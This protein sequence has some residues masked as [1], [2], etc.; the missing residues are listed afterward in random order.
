MAEQENK[1]LHILQHKSSRLQ[2]EDLNQPHIPNLIKYLVPIKS[3]QDIPVFLAQ[4]EAIPNVP[5]YMMGNMGKA[6]NGIPSISFEDRPNFLVGSNAHHQHGLSIHQHDYPKPPV[7]GRNR[8]TERSDVST[9]SSISHADAMTVTKT[10][11]VF[12]SYDP[13]EIT[14]KVREFPGLTAKISNDYVSKSIDVGDNF[15]S[16]K[17]I[18]ESNAEDFSSSDKMLRESKDFV[19]TTEADKEDDLEATST[20]TS[21]VTANSAPSIVYSPITHDGKLISMEECM[22]LFGR[23]VCVYRAT[24]LRTSTDQTRENNLNRY[25]TIAVPKYVVRTS[26]KKNTD[27]VDYSEE[28]LA[29]LLK[30]GKNS[31]ENS[32]STNTELNMVGK[33]SSPKLSRY[34]NPIVQTYD[35][36]DSDESS[37]TASISKNWRT[38]MIGKVKTGIN[39]FLGKS[40]NAEDELSLSPN[41]KEMKESVLNEESL[42]STTSR[43]YNDEKISNLEINQENWATS[44]STWKNIPQEEATVASHIDSGT[45]HDFKDESTNYLEESVTNVY[46]EEEIPQERF[47]EE[48]TAKHD[49]ASGYNLKA[50]DFKKSGF[51]TY[52]NEEYLQSATTRYIHEDHEKSNGSSNEEDSFDTTMGSPVGRL[53]F[54]DNTLLLNSI[55]KVINGFTLDTRVGRTKDL[56]ENVLQLHSRSL[57]PE[58]LE[59]PHLKN[60]LLV[61]RIENMIVEKVKDVLSN[62]TAIPRRDFTND[63]SHGI[64]TDTLR[65]MLEAFPD[66]HRKLP[67]MTIE[68]RQFKNGEW[69]SSSVNLASIVGNRLSKANQINLRECI[70]DLLNSSAIASQADQHIVRNIMIQGIKNSLIS[71]E[72]SGEVADPIISDALNDALR[73]LREPDF[74]QM[75]NDASIVAASESPDLSE[76]Y[77][78]SKDTYIE[79]EIPNEAIGTIK[80]DSRDQTLDGIKKIAMQNEKSE[81]VEP[82]APTTINQKTILQDNNLN[83]SKDSAKANRDRLN[84]EESNRNMFSEAI[85]VSSTEDPHEDSLMEKT[86]PDYA[87]DDI[88][89]PNMALTKNI[90]DETGYTSGITT[91]NLIS[92]A[93]AKHENLEIAVTSSA[94]EIDPTIILARL[95][96]NL[97]PIKYYSPETLK[98]LQDHRIEDENEIVTFANFARESSPDH[99]QISDSTTEEDAARSENAEEQT[100]DALNWKASTVWVDDS[101]LSGN[102]P[103]YGNYESRTLTNEDASKLRQQQQRNFTAEDDLVKIHEVTTE[104]QR[105]YAKT[106]F[107]KSKAHYVEDVS[108]IK[109]LSSNPD[110]ENDNHDLLGNTNDINHVSTEANGAIV[111][112]SKSFLNDDYFLRLFPSD[113][114]SE[115]QRSQL[116]YINDDVKLPL[117]IIKLTDGSYALSISKDICE[118]IIRRRCPCCVPLQGRIV[119]S[120]GKNGQKNAN[121]D[122]KDYRSTD[123]LY[124]PISSITTK[125]TLRMRK[126]EKEKEETNAHK[127][128]KRN[129][130]KNQTISM[131]VVDFARKYNLLLNFDK[132]D[133]LLNGMAS[134]GR[135]VE[136][137]RS[138]RLGES[139]LSKLSEIE[140]NMQSI[141]N[142]E[143][144]EGD[145][146]D[147]DERMMK[148]EEETVYPNILRNV[149]VLNRKE[150]RE[151][152]ESGLTNDEQNAS[153]IKIFT[154]R[155]ARPYR[156]EQ[157]RGT[158]II[159]SILY[160]IKSLFEK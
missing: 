72:K 80:E 127:L 120:S 62:V 94:G 29:S 135:N 142:T 138:G 125:S 42:H 156:Y 11:S 19:E 79:E 91:D 23:D 73:I 86:S 146:S 93:N 108:D 66:F 50:M 118:I 114:I 8:E 155:D 89:S 55:R 77:D 61:P 60:I 111:S 153:R 69:K 38:Q 132:E 131:P 56:D 15:Y 140:G 10:G 147:V 90:G 45:K 39:K 6:I 119:Q 102:N 154:E 116:Y 100:E 158:R 57:L 97:P 121:A 103:R 106:T 54:C 65:S 126:Q 51:D 137:G 159:K 49:F 109:L 128:W 17:M 133:V 35:A 28:Y 75:K 160:W 123:R 59:I 88:I 78:K 150:K 32:E 1:V 7:F 36:D 43:G 96:Y 81:V 26:T 25:T 87:Q 124:G 84:T 122:E 71:D 141:W 148:Y 47:E 145:Y 3:Y 21:Y 18:G 139:K 12:Q 14:G 115:L 24:S 101:V 41:S 64:I 52:S 37:D 58:I 85:T 76:L 82:L 129:L 104:I 149:D 31:N 130:K 113:E 110:S 107:L 136:M 112:S 9:L 33:V 46:T 68:E 2:H 4:H 134:R 34:T 99:I 13:T 105:T 40:K 157:N 151:Y 83:I 152:R 30:F 98:H 20:L 74:N 144:A 5:F 16:A 92:S 22:K 48:I 27:Y 53:P 44:T 143:T 95:E 117:E 67:P 70:R 63:W